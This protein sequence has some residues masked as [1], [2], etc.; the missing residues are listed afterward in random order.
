MVQTSRRARRT[1]PLYL[2]GAFD[3][4]TPSKELVLRNIWIFGPLYAIY[5]IFYLHSWIW[6]PKPGQ[7]VEL[8]Q[9]AHGFSTAWPG[10]PLPTYLTFMVVGLSILW[11]VIIGFIGT[12]VQVM[13]Q[14]AQLDAVHGKPLH[15]KYLFATVR[16][17][18]WR[19][20]GLYVLSTL[21][22]VFSLFILTRRYL[23]APYVM[24]E[25][26]TGIL[27]SMRLSSEL[28]N[29]NPGAVWGVVGVMVLIGLVNI[30]PIIGGLAS[31]MIGSLYSLAPAIRFQQLKKLT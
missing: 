14:R 25:K 27:E 23:L 3:L 8:W 22:I 28:S 15:F 12:A 7:N 17:I 13:S 31:F 11:F 18:G 30:V 20:L 4:F 2:P 16:E 6:T 26:K 1:S 21:A 10:A 29:R 19:M 9:N 5:F 24:L